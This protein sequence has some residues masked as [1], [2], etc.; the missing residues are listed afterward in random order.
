MSAYLQFRWEPND[1][2]HGHRSSLNWLCHYELVLP[3]GEFDV[4]R[5]DADGNKVRSELV[6]PIKGPTGR[7][8]ER[9]PCAPYQDGGELT[10]DDPFR[11]GA[12]AVWDAELLGGL[13]I[14][15]I[16]PDGTRIPKPA[17]AQP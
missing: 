10:Y 5:E 4:R 9:S 14:F 2:T 13:P 1:G 17:G 11:D 3:L 8:S 12:H 6:I 15:A 7:G 16:A